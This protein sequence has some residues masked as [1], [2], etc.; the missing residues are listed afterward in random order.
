[1]DWIDYV[2]S[3]IPSKLVPWIPVFCRAANF[4]YNKNVHRDFVPMPGLPAI[5][6]G[7]NFTTIPGDTTEMTWYEQN[8]NLI[9]KMLANKNRLNKDELNEIGRGVIGEKNLCLIR[10]DVIH[11]VDQ[12]KQR[13]WAFSLRTQDCM[14][15]W[16]QIVKKYEHM[17]V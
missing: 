8:D 11:D 16:D 15:P 10:T 5:T 6:Y 17:F 4:N 14:E 9:E 13:R 1:M 7:L 3:M 2:Q 12:K